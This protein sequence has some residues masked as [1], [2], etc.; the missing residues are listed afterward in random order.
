VAGNL[1]ERGP[2]LL[3]FANSQKLTAL[4]SRSFAD[5][6]AP[7]TI[8]E[9]AVYS[10]LRLAGP[11]TPT[12]L[13]HDLGMPASTM[14]HYL[15]RMDA[16]GHLI[17]RPNPEDRRSS[18]IELSTAGS[19][20]TVACFPAFG[21]AIAAFRQ[22]LMMPEKELLTAMS[23]MNDALHAAHEDLTADTSDERGS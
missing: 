2:F 20:A 10:L 14:T 8:D 6:N 3:H 22:H 13:A 15:R 17:R 16:A 21:A 5:G 11:T 12:R 7:L 18:L 1:V 19:D 9:F 4:L 23:A